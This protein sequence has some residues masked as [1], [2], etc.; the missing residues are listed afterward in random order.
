[1]AS[2]EDVQN[3]GKGMTP[4]ETNKLLKGC[5]IFR[6]LLKMYS[7]QKTKEQFEFVV[8]ALVKKGVEDL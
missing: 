3:G 5:R 7:D 6:E 2:P 8:L 1:M 4:E